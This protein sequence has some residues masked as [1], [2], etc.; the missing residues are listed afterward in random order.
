MGLR[1]NKITDERVLENLPHTSGMIETSKQWLSSNPAGEINKVIDCHWG[2]AHN[3][4]ELGYA[5][6]QQERPITEVRAHLRSAAE[7]ALARFQLLELP[8][9][10]ELREFADFERL[11]NLLIC[12]GSEEMRQRAASIP[13]D[14]YHFTEGAYYRD[15]YRPHPPQ[16]GII[17][18][19]ELLKQVA[20][21]N[22]WDEV[23]FQRS[24]ALCLAPKATKSERIATLP[25]L[26]AVRAALHE[27]AETW[28]RSIGDIVERHKQ[29]AQR[30][31][32]QYDREAF[33][34]LPGLAMA[35]LG[36][37]RGLAC[38]TKSPYLPLALLGDFPA[39]SSTH[40]AAR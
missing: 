36:M 1:L 23:A 6:Y 15:S 28:N 16:L 22:A 8:S 29:I 24:K 11:L 26:E 39:N 25:K 20:A 34:C 18:Y 40:F 13:K 31:D 33:V 37:Q 14:I 17:E 35:Q 21:G 9:D 7:H 27:D 2:L 4:S 30:G 10:R 3:Y 5:L 19:L 12:F 38:D 32:W